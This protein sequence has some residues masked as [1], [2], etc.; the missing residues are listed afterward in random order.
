MAFA[1]TIFQIGSGNYA[2]FTEYTERAPKLLAAKDSLQK[3]VFGTGFFD[4]W[5]LESTD[6]PATSYPEL[7]TIVLIIKPEIRKDYTSYNTEFWGNY[8]S[9]E[10]PIYSLAD[11]LWE[12]RCPNLKTIRIEWD[13][14]TLVSWHFY[15]GDYEYDRYGRYPQDDYDACDEP[16]DAKLMFERFFSELKLDFCWITQH[17][18]DFVLPGCL[19]PNSCSPHC[20]RLLPNPLEEGK[21]H[22]EAAFDA[23]L[24]RYEKSRNYN[25]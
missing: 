8:D 18:I 22:D 15:D 14:T 7:K 6:L 3:L 16:L 9:I 17:G 20:C 1:P 4:F 23:I 10:K 5:S 25:Y 12:N 21:A 2:S 11:W 13:T 24:A 19:I